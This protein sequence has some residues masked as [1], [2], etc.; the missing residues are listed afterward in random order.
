MPELPTDIKQKPSKDEFDRQMKQIDADA[1]ELRVR[2]EEL[3]HK[4]KMVY[5]GGRADAGNESYH[6]LISSNIEEVKKIRNEKRGKL[7]RM[8]EL[9]QRQQTL[10]QERQAILKNVP[11]NYQTYEEV[12]QAIKEK[13]KKYETT[14]LKPNDEKAILKD[15]D[16]LQKVLPEMKKLTVIEPELKKIKE[17]RKKISADLD[18]V[19]QLIDDRDQKINEGKQKNQ[20]V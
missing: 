3:R 11:R 4:R 20:A 18:I 13:K 15:I 10:D 7:E 14:S 8:N 5:E 17:E 1:N 16:T 12:E 2:I 19:N 9:K 6:D